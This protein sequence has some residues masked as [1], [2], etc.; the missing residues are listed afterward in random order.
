M[1]ANNDNEIHL[2]Q[3]RQIDFRRFL[4]KKMIGVNILKSYS[5]IID[6]EF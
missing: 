3:K 6:F 2:F 5:K 4:L 1:V